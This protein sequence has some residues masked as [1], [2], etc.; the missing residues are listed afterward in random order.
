[1]SELQDTNFNTTAQIE[2]KG[3]TCTGHKKE[4]EENRTLGDC[5]N[6]QGFCFFL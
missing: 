2:W 6:F 1:M 3:S 5:H 4:A